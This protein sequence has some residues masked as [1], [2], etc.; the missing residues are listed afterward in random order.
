MWAELYTKIRA[1]GEANDVHRT[2]LTVGACPSGPKAPTHM[3]VEE[4]EPYDMHKKEDALVKENAGAFPNGGCVRVIQ[5][6]Q[7][8][9]GGRAAS[10][11]RLHSLGVRGSRE[12]SVPSPGCRGEGGALRGHGTI[13]G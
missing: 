9:G 11:P 3:E 12:L 7:G 1:A 5:A 13:G 8:G 6:R 2:V 10:R 4:D